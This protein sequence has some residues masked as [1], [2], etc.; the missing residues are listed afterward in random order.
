[1]EVL[2]MQGPEEKLNQDANGERVLS[3]RGILSHY[4]H[5]QAGRRRA[6]ECGFCNT[7]LLAVVKDPEIQPKESGD[8]LAEGDRS[9]EE[10]AAASTS[11]SRGYWD[12][13]PV[14]R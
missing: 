7:G 14:L 6:Q 12:P 3:S 5:T 10:E 8:S 2:I 4:R 1:M 11:A 13:G 9:D